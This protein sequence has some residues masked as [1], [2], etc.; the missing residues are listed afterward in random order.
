[1]MIKEYIESQEGIIHRKERDKY[2]KE[3]SF[4]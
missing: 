3:N 1:M 4:H 2:Q